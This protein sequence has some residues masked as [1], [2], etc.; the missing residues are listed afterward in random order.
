MSNTYNLLKSRTFWLLVLA[1]FIPVAN[2][3]VPTLPPAWQAAVSVILSFAAI[4]TH[5]DTAQKSGAVN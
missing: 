1:A 4:I 3:I 5:N 2:A